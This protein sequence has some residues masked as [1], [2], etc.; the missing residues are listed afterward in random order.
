MASGNYSGPGQPRGKPIAEVNQRCKL[1]G[2]RNCLQF[3]AT[4]ASS[5]LNQSRVAS[6]FRLSLEPLLRV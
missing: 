5:S 3:S 4:L 2:T 6:N 1:S